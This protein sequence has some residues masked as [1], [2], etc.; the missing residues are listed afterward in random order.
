MYVSLINA[1]KALK[2]LVVMSEDLE[3]L[4]NSLYDN[5][6][7]ALWANKGFLSLKSLSSW[8]EDLNERIS[9]L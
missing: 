2:G 1:K 5:Q 6:V 8:I 7:P 4:T 9:F 3:K